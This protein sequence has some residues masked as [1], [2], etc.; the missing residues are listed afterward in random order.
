LLATTGSALV[1][2]TDIEADGTVSLR[3]GDN[4]FGRRPLP[5]TQFTASYR[6]GIGT[7]G[8]IGPD[9]LFHLAL[10]LPEVT[11]V[12]NITAGEGGRNPETNAQ[13]RKRAPFLFKTQERAVT[14]EDYQTLGRRVAGIQDVSCAYIHTGSWITTFALPDPEGRIET[15]DALRT[16]LRD[17]YEVFRLAAH[18]VEVSSPVYVPLEIT[19]H[20]C[21]APN[22]SRSQV[23]QQLLRLFSSR[24][25]PD[26]S[27]GLLHPNRFRA[28][29]TFHLS[30]L[31][32][33]AQ[34]LDGVIAAKALRFRRFGDPR[35]SGLGDRK[36]T[37][38]RTEIARVD[39]NISNPANGVF[40]VE[41]DGGR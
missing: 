37:F 2:T 15:S 27:L 28:G 35:T 25:L 30:P 11:E 34:K 22:A 7:A 10:P 1:F 40:E 36:L 20:V 19:L 23:R 16:A 12:R 26:G 24:R 9:K 21:V 14:R 41:M 17:H 4:T 18:D 32:A 5:G 6:V 8:H 39:N 38:S 31:I 3:F 13:I 29:E 33:A